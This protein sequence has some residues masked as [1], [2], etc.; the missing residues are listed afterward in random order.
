MIRSKEK[1]KYFY[2]KR[3]N[4][5]TFSAGDFVYLLKEPLKGKLQD[6]YTGLHLIEEVIPP[7][8]VRLFIQGKSR[9]VHMDKLK[10]AHGIDMEEPG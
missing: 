9:I 6:Q 2:D 7:R 8:N 5:R 10:L 1:S 4:L 3:I